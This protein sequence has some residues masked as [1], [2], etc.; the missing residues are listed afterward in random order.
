MKRGKEISLNVPYEY[1]VI[2]GTVDNKNPKSIYIQISAWGKPRTD[3]EGEY[4]SILKQKSKRVKKKLFEVLGEDKFYRD[5]SI[6]D[7]NMASSGISLGKRSFMSV[8]M[9]LFQ[10][11]PLIPIN[12]NDLIP[13]LNEISSSII[14]DVF[15]KDEDFRFYRKKM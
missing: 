8:E 9:T 15:E 7:F 2:S 5:R 12:S 11:E 3:R 4:D 6:V 13:T 14:G 1:N 10:K